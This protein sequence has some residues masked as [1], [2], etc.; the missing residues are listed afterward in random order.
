MWLVIIY[1]VV[2]FMR[3]RYRIGILVPQLA[4]KYSFFRKIIPCVLQVPLAVLWALYILTAQYCNNALG[5]L[6]DTFIAVIK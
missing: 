4:E 3:E 6:V 2:A 5:G 1:I